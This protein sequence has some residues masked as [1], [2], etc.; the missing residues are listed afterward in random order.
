M[1][2][3]NTRFS[4]L[5]NAKST[6]SDVFGITTTLVVSFYLAQY[7]QRGCHPTGAQRISEATRARLV[8]QP[9]SWHWIHCKPLDVKGMVKSMAGEGNVGPGK[10]FLNDDCLATF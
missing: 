4:S 1:H 5:L 9:V 8:C 2:D 7:G 3:S 6:Y 10:Q